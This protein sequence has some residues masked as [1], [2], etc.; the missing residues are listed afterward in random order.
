[1]LLKQSNTMRETKNKTLLI[2]YQSMACFSYNIT[3][4]GTFDNVLKQIDKQLIEIEILFKW[5]F[6][7]HRLEY[8]Q[9]YLIL[10]IAITIIK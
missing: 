3:L 1:M 7:T 10:N 2:V 5:E 8:K 9:Q 4:S 6:D